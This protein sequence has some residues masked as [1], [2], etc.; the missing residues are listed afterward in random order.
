MGM[1]KYKTQRFDPWQVITNVAPDFLNDNLVY[2]KSA[3]KNY[4]H[5]IKKDQKH[6]GTAIFTNDFVVKAVQYLTKVNDPVLVGDVHL[7]Q[8][9]S[10]A[11]LDAQGKPFPGVR[12]RIFI[13]I[14]KAINGTKLF[15]ERR[16]SART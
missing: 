1:K 14:Q 8:V 4:T 15:R 16:I 10:P 7:I 3:N 9:F 6:D 12:E 5:W 2:D 11:I 13:P